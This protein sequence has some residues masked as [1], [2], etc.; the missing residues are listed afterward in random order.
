MVVAP[1]VAEGAELVGVFQRP[2][3]D[4]GVEDQTG[5]RQRNAGWCTPHDSGVG[6][7][8]G[9]VVGKQRYAFATR[10]AASEPVSS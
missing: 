5:V 2:S 1:S 9:F 10:V 4:G 6:V 7:Q 8:V 3:V